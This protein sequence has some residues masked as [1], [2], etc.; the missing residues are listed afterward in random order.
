MACTLMVRPATCGI[1]RAV[2]IAGLIG[3]VIDPCAITGIADTQI[4]GHVGQNES[5]ERSETE[6]SWW[7][8]LLLIIV[9]DGCAALIHACSSAGNPL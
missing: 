9:S 2:G 4:G 7:A 6:D 5:E 3:D 8:E 1:A